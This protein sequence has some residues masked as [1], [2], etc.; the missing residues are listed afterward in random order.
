MSYSNEERKNKQN[1]NHNNNNNNKNHTWK[2]LSFFLIG[3][4]VSSLGTTVAFGKFQIP[5]F[6]ENEQLL[7]NSPSIIPPAYATG[8]LANVSVL[9]SDSIY[10][11]TSYYNIGFTT[12]TTGTI[13]TIEMTFPSGFVV[14][15][16]KLIQSQGTGT[17]SLSTSGQTVKFTVTTP[18]SVSAGKAMTI[19]FGGIVNSAV[20]SNQVSVTT[21]DA[22]NVIIDGP[23]SS[24]TF[25]LIKVTSS[26][27]DG[28]SITSSKI[29]DGS[30]G[31]ADLAPNSV[32]SSKIG[33]GSMVYADLSRSFVR[34]EHRDDCNC[35]GTGWD[36]DG[37]NLEAILV[38]DDAVTN[39]SVISVTLTNAAYMICWTEDPSTGN[40][41][42]VCDR[43]IPNGA[44]L[45]YAILNGAS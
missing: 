7:I 36:P 31:I 15:A 28:N 42:V 16:A 13:K 38:Y 35:G 24:A 1:S 2:L 14:S 29:V 4:L 10:K 37:S 40:F 23:T 17:G 3:A 32:D 33:D 30:I 8:A 25:T 18:V 41:F 12:G 5:F 19:M 6:S 45:N 20:T 21:K 9:P 27:I 34:I 22:S 44:G 39:N 26:M 11:A 43:I